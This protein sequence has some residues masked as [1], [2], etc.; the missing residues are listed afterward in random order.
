M[1]SKLLTRIDAKTVKDISTKTANLINGG[2]DKRI[3]FH[4]IPKCGGTSINKALQACYVKWSLWE[5]STVLNL[6]SAASWKSAQIL[7]DEELLPDTA[8]DSAVM[9]LREQLLVYFMNLDS[10]HYISGHFPFSPVAYEHCSNRYEF[11]TILRDPIDRWLSS[12]FY[13][14]CRQ[15]SSY[16]KIATSLEDYISSDFGKSQGYE[17]A[18]FL[19][20]LG[21]DGSFMTLQA[22]QQ[23]KD[24]LH[25]FH[26]IGFLDDMA[27]F[28]SSFKERYGKALQVRTLN[29]R[30][31]TEK[32][33]N[34]SIT[35]DMMK[36]I[37]EICK[38]DIEVYNYAVEHF[39]KS[40]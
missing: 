23:A 4:H 6:N 33:L 34:E 1:L 31:E 40:A 21:Q 10:V 35:E 18:K 37:Q 3:Y 14:N 5:S 28:K 16:R 24:N 26:L 2:L 30:P 12:Y 7:F 29:K 15:K 17:Y 32:S 27:T 9:K 38:P 39:K 36:S 22:V 11:I 20:G 25:K 13:N 19:G 8:D